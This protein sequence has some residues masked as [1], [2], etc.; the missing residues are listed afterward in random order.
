MENGKK[1]REM[2][3]VI[4]ERY[5]KEPSELLTKM[6]WKTLK[7]YSDNNCIA[8]LNHVFRYGKFFKDIVPDLLD[9]LENINPVPELQDIA[10]IEADRI[11]SHLKFYGALK[12]LKLDNLVSKH[13]METRWKYQSWASTILESEIVWWKKEFIESFK[14]FQK[15]ENLEQLENNNKVLPLINN[16]CEKIG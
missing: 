7:E 9:F 1:F 11:L 10:I 5:E 15:V 12:P 6:I 8:A 13:L 14:S 3:T 2:I 4:C 16:I